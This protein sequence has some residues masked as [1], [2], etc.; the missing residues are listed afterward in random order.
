M[1]LK[2]GYLFQCPPWARG[3]CPFRAC[4]THLRNL[5]LLYF[6]AKFFITI[7]YIIIYRKVTTLFSYLQEISGKSYRKSFYG[8][9]QVHEEEYSSGSVSQLKWFNQAT[10]VVQ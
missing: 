8:C 10:Q 6:Q 7:C 1:Q 4:G 9:T 3:F 5:N 2:I